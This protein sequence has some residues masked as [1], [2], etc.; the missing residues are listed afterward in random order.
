MFYLKPFAWHLDLGVYKSVETI[1]DSDGDLSG[2]Y[3]YF[4][5]NIIISTLFLS[6]LRG[7][8]SGYDNW[9]VEYD[10]TDINL[11]IISLAKG[12]YTIG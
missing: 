4:H 11:L 1:E 9:W 12:R 2:E 5:H 10:W 6:S 3:L 8:S 7:E